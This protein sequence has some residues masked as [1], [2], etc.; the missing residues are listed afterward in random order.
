VSLDLDAVE[1]AIMVRLAEG[2]RVSH[3]M[4][5]YDRLYKLGLV[6]GEFTPW[7]DLKQLGLSSEQQYRLLLT[8][9][10]EIWAHAYAQGFACGRASR[11]AS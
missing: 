4:R 11:R 9:R 5:G 7:A 10:G 8:D 1:L 6:D 3:P 2:E